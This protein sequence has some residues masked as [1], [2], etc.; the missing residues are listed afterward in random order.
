M[1]LI[2]VIM[3]VWH[4]III[5]IYTHILYINKHVQCHVIMYLAIVLFTD[6]DI[7]IVS[8]GSSVVGTWVIFADS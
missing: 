5:S 4:S 3:H 7:I 6:G 2:L 1:T 8:V